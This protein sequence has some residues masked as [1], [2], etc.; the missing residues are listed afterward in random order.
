MS[1]PPG[2]ALATAVFPR[3]MCWN[4]LREN[5]DVQIT[6]NNTKQRQIAPKILAL[7]QSRLTLG[8][9]TFNWLLWYRVKRFTYATGHGAL[10]GFATLPWGAK[11]G[12]TPS[13]TAWILIRIDV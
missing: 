7:P 11:K 3:W 8:V 2:R 9:A 13:Q 5:F 6:P 10:A 4:V 1:Q 12:V